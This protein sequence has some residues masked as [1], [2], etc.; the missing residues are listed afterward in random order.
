[1]KDFSE[2]TVVLSERTKSIF[3]QTRTTQS[4]Q[5]AREIEPG[6]LLRGFFP[7]APRFVKLP[8]FRML[9]KEENGFGTKH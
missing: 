1:M 6:S 7:R 9:S 3:P 5:E 4:L 2:R 8:A